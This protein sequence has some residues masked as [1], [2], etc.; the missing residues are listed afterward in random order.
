MKAISL[1]SSGLDSVAALAIAAE[2][3]EIEMAITFD[4]G[5]R[6]AERE[7]E[8]AGKVCKHFGIE[9]QVIKLDWLAGITSTSLVNREA[10]V[11]ELS[12]E[13]ITENAPAEITEASAKAVWVPNRNG[14]MLNIAASFAESKGCEYLIVGFNGEEAG[15]FP[16]NSLEYV[17]AMDHAF[18][19]ST[20][21]GVKVLAP[22]IELDKP[23]IVRKALET[24]APLEYSWSCYHGGEVPCQKC[25]SC[26][27]RARAFK[28]AGMKDPLLEK[29]GA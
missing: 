1:L 26:V 14:V 5:Q 9:Q 3:L 20:Q 22:L 2:S 11:P 4:Y 28:A 7:I 15:T 25:E 24:K 12:F 21:N 17:Q 10:D 18:S 8:H 27:R 13:D 6:S 16:D 19:Y 23:G 29:L